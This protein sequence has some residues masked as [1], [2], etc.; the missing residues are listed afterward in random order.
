MDFQQIRKYVKGV[1]TNSFLNKTTLDKL[2]TSDE[3]NLLF[4]GKK[5]NGSESNKVVYGG[6]DVNNVIYELTSSVEGTEWVATEDCYF[7][8]ELVGGN[9]NGSNFAIDGIGVGSHYSSSTISSSHFP[10][11]V[12]KGQTVKYK[13]MSSDFIRTGKFYG[14]KKSENIL[15]NYSTE[16]RVVGTWIDGKPLYEKVITFSLT[17]SGNLSYPHNIENLHEI[18]FIS[19]LHGNNENGIKT[20][21]TYVPWYNEASIYLD[22]ITTTDI[23]VYHNS[24]RTEFYEFIL[25]YTKT[26]D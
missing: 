25:R 4:D 2:S 13:A 9:N 11:L 8:G 15:H 12:L 20:C 19:M 22:E 24:N 21:R 14:I 3:G 23:L 6:I 7:I 17:G 18:H 1:L 26:T 10:I 16:E 5:I